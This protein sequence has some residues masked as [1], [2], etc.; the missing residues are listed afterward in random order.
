MEERSGECEGTRQMKEGNHLYITQ[1]TKTQYNCVR[2]CVCVCVHFSVCHFIVRWRKG[3][4]NGIGEELILKDRIH[5]VRV[6][7]FM[8]ILT[9]S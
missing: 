8:L 2:V 6:C 3:E 5:G 9:H 7:V 1:K 4:C